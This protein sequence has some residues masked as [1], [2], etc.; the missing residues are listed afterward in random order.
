M[1][2]VFGGEVCFSK[3]FNWYLFLLFFY[4]LIFFVVVMGIMLIDFDFFISYLNVWLY[5]YQ[6][7]NV[8]IFDGFKFDFFIEFIIGLV[9]FQLKVGFGGICFVKGLDDV[10]KLVILYVFLIY[11]LV[12]VVLLVKFVGWFFNWC[13]SRCVKV[14]FFCVLCIIV[15]FCYIDII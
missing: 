1:S 4:G 15:V 7:M 8:L 3:C 5:F 6:V 9:N 12:L 11:V 13:F 2:V 10:D 14:V